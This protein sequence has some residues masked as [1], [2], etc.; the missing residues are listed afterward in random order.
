MTSGIQ[1]LFNHN[2]EL[3]RLSDKTV[4]YLRIQ[5][6][7]KGMGFFRQTIDIIMEAVQD[8]TLNQEYFN[9]VSELVNIQSMNY[10]LGELLAAQENH[11]YI[12]LADLLELQW[13]PFIISLQEYTA[14]QEV[15]MFDAD[16]FEKNTNALLT[17]S[18]EIGRQL[19]VEGPYQS[20]SEDGYILEYTSCGLPTFALYDQQ[21]KY[22]YHSNGHVLQE[23]ALVAGEW[24]E[25]D[26]SEYIIY[27]LGLGYHIKELA[28]IDD[29]NIIH[30]YE[31]DWNIIRLACT[32]SS[33]SELLNSGRVVIYFD[34]DFKKLDAHRKLMD[35]DTVFAVHYPSL[36]NIKDSKVREKLEEYFML[37]SSVKNQINQLNRNFKLNINHYDASVDSLEESFKGKDLYII[38]AG[39]SLD[40]NFKQLK[41]VGHNAIILAT[42]TI[43]K[44]L[45]DE[46]IQPDY[47]IISDGNSIVYWQID[48]VEQS[49]I[50][51]LFLSTAYY[52]VSQ[53]YSGKKYLIC[54]NGF[55]M[56]EEYAAKKGFRLYQTGGSV[57]TTAL[58]IGISFCCRRIIFLGLDLAYTNN[59]NHA[60]GTPNA[61]KINPGEHKMVEDIS[62]NLISTGK[63]LDIYRK[64]IENRIKDVHGVEIIDATEGGAKIKGME[65]RKLSQCI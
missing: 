36:R 27:G 62:G 60:L 51:L 58:D 30:V 64:W 40:K 22:Y 63:N 32:I 25:P 29:S 12:L 43:Y 45:L 26:K 61:N 11:D 54:Q 3:L 7:Y 35:D 13:N 14:G 23:A 47:V 42:G 59:A 24:F 41:Q 52:K 9:Q 34:P 28:D 53:N 49:K 6:F 65:I 20:Y 10:M 56:A 15:L 16:L 37:Y 48:G 44:K 33:I 55:Q 1:K 31:S 38:A 21:K 8:I 5:N 4:S 50:P 2:I 39:P 57:S 17:N 19:K 18:E 46:G